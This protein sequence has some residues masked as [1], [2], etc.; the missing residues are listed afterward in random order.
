MGGLGSRGPSDVGEYL[1]SEPTAEPAPQR[2]RKKKKA[3]T[4]GRNLH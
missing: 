3:A 2:R 4:I 1:S